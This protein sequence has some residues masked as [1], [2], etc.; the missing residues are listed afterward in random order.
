[1]ENLFRIVFHFIDSINT[2]LGQLSTADKVVSPILK[3]SRKKYFRDRILDWILIGKINFISSSIILEIFSRIL[4][5][6]KKI[7]E[8][9]YKS[10]LRECYS[11]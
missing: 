8:F 10:I 6:L 4:K 5:Y 11:C 1:M 2:I 9:F 7:C 3:D